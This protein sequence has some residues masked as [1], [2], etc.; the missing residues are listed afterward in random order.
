[1]RIGSMQLPEDTVLQVMDR[2]R[3]ASLGGG[4]RVTRNGRGEPEE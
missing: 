3:R 2:A 1:M 4:Q